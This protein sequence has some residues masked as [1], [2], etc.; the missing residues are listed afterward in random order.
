MLLQM[1]FSFFFMAEQH[2]IVYIYH[3]FFIHSSVDGQLGCFHILAIVNSVAMNIGMH[4]SFPIRVFCRYM[5][6][7]GIARS[8]DNSIQFFKEPPYCFAQWMHQFTFPP[9]VQEGFLFSTPSPAFVICR[10]F[11][12]GQSDWCEV[13]PHCSFDLHFSF[14]FFLRNS[15]S[16]MYLFIYL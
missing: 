8:Y 16:F 2:S 14:F 15:R 9:T 4:V 7:H 3:T 12:D 6:R 5:P 1:A 13:V 10:L 11:N